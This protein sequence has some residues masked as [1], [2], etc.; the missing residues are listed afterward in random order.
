MPISP[1]NKVRYSED[2]PAIRAAILERAGHKCERCGVPNYARI[3]RR[4]DDAAVWELERDLLLAQDHEPD[5]DAYRAP[6]KVVL[7][8]AHLN[9]QP[10]DNRLENIQALCNLCH[11]RHDAVEHV[12][13]RR[14]NRHRRAG[15]QTLMEAP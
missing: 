4:K 10:E 1:E 13:S 14:A 15:Q 9:H 11:L 2:W 6:V 7:T 3:V 5:W 12:R 8:C